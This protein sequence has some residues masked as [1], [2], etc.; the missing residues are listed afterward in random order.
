M[1]SEYSEAYVWIWLQ[2]ETSP[3]VAGRLEAEDGFIRFNYGRSYLE[4]VEAGL[5]CMSIYEPDAGVHKGR[6]S[7]QLGAPCDHPQDAR[8]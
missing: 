8:A 2:G 3:V 5:P 4:R 1:T 6:C 7:R